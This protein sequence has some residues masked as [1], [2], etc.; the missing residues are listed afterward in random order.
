MLIHL[1]S[2]QSTIDKTTGI[3]VEILN[4]DHLDKKGEELVIQL[5]VMEV[6]E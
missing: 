1:S 3:Q 4:L 6:D 5:I 2:F